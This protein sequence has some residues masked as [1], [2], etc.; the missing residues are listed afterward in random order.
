V[1]VVVPIMM[2]TMGVAIA[3][4][5]TR[6][7]V[8]ND[9]VDRSHGL[10]RAREG[11]DGSLLVP[12]WLAEYGTAAAL[13]LG[14]LGLLIDTDWGPSV[15]AIGAGALLYTSINSLGWSL[16][17]RERFTYA[18]PMAAGI[19]VGLVSSAYLVAN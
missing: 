5:W 10:L 17:K 4:V 7:I 9:L 11:G 2:I 19:V 13:V 16:A 12:H 6:D 3:G 18:V 8:S 14:A 15:A 1:D